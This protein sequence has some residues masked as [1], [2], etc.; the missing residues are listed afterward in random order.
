MS[1]STALSGDQTRK[2]IL[3]GLLGA[4]THGRRPADAMVRTLASA[5]FAGLIAW[6]LLGMVR[7]DRL[8]DRAQ[9]A[10]QQAALVGAIERLAGSM[11]RQAQALAAREQ[12]DATVRRI[13]LDG[14]CGTPGPQMRAGRATASR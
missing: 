8:A 12:E 6:A 7:E 14:L 5:G 4:L 3:R 1:A 13:V 9:Q 11:D 2:R 10:Q